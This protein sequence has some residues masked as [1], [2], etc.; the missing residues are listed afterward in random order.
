MLENTMNTFFKAD[1]RLY[2]ISGINYIDISNLFFDKKLVV[3]HLSGV[4]I[5]TGADSSDLINILNLKYLEKYFNSDPN[6]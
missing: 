4:I 5:L 2:P 1:E 3:N 6:S